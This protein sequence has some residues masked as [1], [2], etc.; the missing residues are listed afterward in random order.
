[1]EGLI[2]TAAERRKI[3]ADMKLAQVKG[4]KPGY[5]RSPGRV[6]NQFVD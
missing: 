4:A 1:L 6:R 2:E 5:Q 3:A